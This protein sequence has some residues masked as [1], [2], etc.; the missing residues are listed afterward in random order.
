MKVMSV[1]VRWVN[2]GDLHLKPCL[3]VLVEST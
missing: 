2:Y 3:R 1:K